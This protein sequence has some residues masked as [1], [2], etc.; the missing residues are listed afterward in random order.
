MNGEESQAQM[1]AVLKAEVKASAARR[2]E[3]ASMKRVE[4]TS[5]SASFPDASGDAPRMRF[6]DSPLQRGATHSSPR[7]TTTGPETSLR[8]QLQS[9]SAVGI[10]RTP[11][12]LAEDIGRGFEA[13][14]SPEL[15]I[16]LHLGEVDL[17]F[18]MFYIDNVFPLLFPFYSAPL[19]DGG[20]GWLLVQLLRDATLL[21]TTSCLSVFFFSLLIQETSKDR[22]AACNTM[23]WDRLTWQME[24]AFSTVQ[25]D[26]RLIENATRIPD[27]SPSSDMGVSRLCR[28]LGSILQLLCFEVGTGN[29]ANCETHLHAA[30]T[31]FETIM[32]EY[33]MDT[34]DSGKSR[35]SLPLVLDA[36]ARPPWSLGSLNGSLPRNADQA[37][38]CF[39]AA[40][41]FVDDIIIS[42]ALAK[43]PQLR[44]YHPYLL[45]A[46]NSVV[47]LLNSNGGGSDGRLST[48][49]TDSV[50]GCQSW[51]LLL[52]GQIAALDSWKKEHQSNAELDVM[53]LVSRANDIKVAL[54]NGIDELR[55]MSSAFHTQCLAGVQLSTL[56]GPQQQ[57]GE[58]SNHTMK[59]TGIWAHA[60]LAYL[61]VVVSGWQP[62]APATR[63]PV[64]ETLASLKQAAATKGTA[65]LRTLA[66]PF[67]VAGCLAQPG[68]QA[69]VR[70]I[71]ADL[72]AL[73]SF[74]MLR[75][76]ME[77]VELAWDKQDEVGGQE[78]GRWNAGSLDLATCFR[79]LGY[80]VLLV[81]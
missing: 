78:H 74:S 1:A 40:V 4:P 35:P 33:G 44:A 63:N 73:G 17:G 66:W 30:V 9:Y 39:F 64:M 27:S 67:C 79:S 20:R 38:F 26:I 7:T 72:G 48:L 3:L 23:A 77:I 57:A 37:A 81:S 46:S 8:V 13:T 53:E 16:G 24:R 2:R 76:A 58:Q 15:A 28:L 52:I 21:N 14:G 25:S 62:Y 49:D 42:T 70:A 32:K 45:P 50:N 19:L 10:T 55:A 12:P 56:G 59:I 11:R 69:E 22:S 5:T 31:L 60:A 68:Q 34:D 71:V 47:G 36:M 80:P 43:A 6:L 75:L 51:V 18:V 65:V 61:S 54:Q 41:L 29:S